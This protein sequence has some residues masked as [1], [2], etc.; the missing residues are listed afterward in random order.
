[1]L[2]IGA[3]D[4][5]DAGF[6]FGQIGLKLLDMYKLKEYLPRVYAAFYGTELSV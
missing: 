4:D 2:C 1:M 5:I 3:K 6:R